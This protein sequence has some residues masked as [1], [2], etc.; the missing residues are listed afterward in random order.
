LPDEEQMLMRSQLGRPKAMRPDHGEIRFSWYRK[1]D[2]PI[3]YVGV[4][5][6]MRTKDDSYQSTCGKER[7]LHYNRKPTVT[8]KGD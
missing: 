6:G 5:R 1:I 4:V 7:K 8:E 3:G 2:L